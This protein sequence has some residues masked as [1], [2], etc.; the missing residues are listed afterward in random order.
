MGGIDEKGVVMDDFNVMGRLL[1]PDF[2]FK[3]LPPVER[4]GDILGW[5]ECFVRCDDFVYN[6][7]KGTCCCKSF[8][9]NLMWRYRP[10]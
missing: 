10:N 1:R 4:N 9:T 5:L 3:P 8:R 6:W 7:T 2:S